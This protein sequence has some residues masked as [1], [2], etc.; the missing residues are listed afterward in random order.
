MEPYLTTDEVAE[1]LRTSSSTVRYWRHIGYGPISV[2][3]GRRILYRPSDVAA[4]VDHLREGQAQP[5][6]RQRG[7][8]R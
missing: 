3:V 6:D 1:A 2:K 5:G 7:H 4:W 8:D